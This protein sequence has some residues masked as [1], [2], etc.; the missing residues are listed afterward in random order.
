MDANPRRRPL[1]KTLQA[2]GG[3][4][5]LFALAGL[6]GL[7]IAQLAILTHVGFNAVAVASRIEFSG[8]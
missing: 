7:A 6:V 8:F 2:T 1:A 4:L 3:E 5:L